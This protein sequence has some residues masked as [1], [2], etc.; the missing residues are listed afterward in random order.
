MG[1]HISV[2]SVYWWNSLHFSNLSQTHFPASGSFDLDFYTCV[3]RPHS[4]PVWGQIYLKRVRV[5]IGGPSSDGLTGRAFM[6]S[7]QLSLLSGDIC[8]LMSLPS[9]S[10]IDYVSK[11]ICLSVLFRP[12]M[13]FWL[14]SISQF[15]Q[16]LHI[17]LGKDA[18]EKHLLG[19]RTV[20]SLCLLFFSRVALKTHWLTGVL[21]G[22]L[23]FSFAQRVVCL[24]FV[25]WNG[26][27]RHSP[28]W[29]P[30]FLSTDTRGLQNKG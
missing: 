4:L 13:L 29:H 1:W 24:P 5:G 15:A 21:S 20:L 8:S 6:L 11:F 3:S 28:S 7:D 10:N 30:T 17:F 16:R 19:W 22:I 23:F 2:F 27:E 26:A 18:W 9:W 25:L 12:S 14:G